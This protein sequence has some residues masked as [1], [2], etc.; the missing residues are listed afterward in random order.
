MTGFNWILKGELAGSA[1][2]GLYSEWE[3]D[4]RFLKNYGIDY[5]I[6]LTEKPL[7][8]EPAIESGFHFHHFPIRDMDFPMPRNAH[9][10]LDLI[11]R[12]IRNGHRFLLHCKGGVGRTGLMCASFLVLR[13]ESANEAIRKVRSVMST[14]IQT[15][16]QEMFVHNFE[17]Y[18]K[19]SVEDQS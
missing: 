8:K 19:K 10:A 3:D 13:G 2:P 11:E 15:Q 16:G 6:S 18:L 1:Q 12:E 17:R 7:I 4:I 9:Q 5:I 14:Y